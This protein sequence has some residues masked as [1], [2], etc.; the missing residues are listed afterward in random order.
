MSSVSCL[1]IYRYK[2][3]HVQIGI[4]PF[5]LYFNEKH[6][7]IS[8]AAQPHKQVVIFHSLTAKLAFADG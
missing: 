8:A 3:I 5:T 7:H 2:Y 1:N 6:N 4:H